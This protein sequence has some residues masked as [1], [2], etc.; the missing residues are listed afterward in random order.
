[1]MV[2][3]MDRIVGPESINR[4]CQQRLAQTLLSS[5][6]YEEALEICRT[7]HWEGVLRALS[8]MRPDTASPTEH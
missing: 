3:I 2:V 1:M 7:N 4:E 6:G 5:C 8:G